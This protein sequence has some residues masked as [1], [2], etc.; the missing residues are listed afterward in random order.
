MDEPKIGE[1]PAEQQPPMS[2]VARERMVLIIANNGKVIEDCKKVLEI[3]NA[4]PSLD[5]SFCRL[6]GITNKSQV[7]D[8]SN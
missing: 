6:F 3:L 5:A 1:S 4:D 7:R 8:V 2:T